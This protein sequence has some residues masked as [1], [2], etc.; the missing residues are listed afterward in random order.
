MDATE[1]KVT[2][3]VHPHATI[4]YRTD[5][6]PSNQC[7]FPLNAANVADVTSQLESE[8]KKSDAMKVIAAAG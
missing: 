7:T 3:S 8:L 2:L 5:E 1:P 6:H 4:G